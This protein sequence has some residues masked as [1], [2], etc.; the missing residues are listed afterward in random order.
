MPR[1]LAAAAIALGA[2]LP[3]QCPSVAHA[4]PLV[5]PVV[6]ASIAPVHSL[7]AAVM[8]GVAEPRLLVPGG[9]SPHAYALRPSDARALQSASLVVW[10]G[11]GL[12]TFLE[13]SITSLASGAQ[14]LRLADT[15][16]LRLL[17][18]RGTDPDDDG[19][20]AHPHGHVHAGHEHEHEP[21]P[22]ADRHL[23]GI[24]MHLWLDPENGWRMAERI[25]E[26]LAA[27]DPA[28][29]AAYRR[30]VG[31]LRERL[32]SL[33]ERIARRMAG[34]AGR[35]FIVFHDGYRYFEDRYGL[36]PAEVLTVNPEASP[37]ADR[38]RRIRSRILEGNVGCL[39]IEPQFPAAI[40]GTLVAGT[41]ARIGR[42]DP[43]GAAL[44]PGPGLYEQLLSG[45]A[46]SFADCLLP[47]AAGR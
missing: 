27:M 19:G 24:D 22:G 38:V 11:P 42:L 7:V 4:S 8:Q 32:V 36:V 46:A 28:N 6:V 34:L 47:P 43:L 18:L 20:H 35:G 15:P 17:P 37:G 45:L 14:V 10:I 13:R 44:A 33:D 41:A 1:T 21:A 2:F 40:A 25:G 12:E 9:S 29:A 39:F 30:N 5:S 16:G 23:A 31:A 3:W 26:T